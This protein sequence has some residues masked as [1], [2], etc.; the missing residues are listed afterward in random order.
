MMT[1]PELDLAL[2][3]NEHA[4][5]KNVHHQTYIITDVDYPITFYT[6]YEGSKYNDL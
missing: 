1:F 3:V 5:S 6:F 2:P 4:H